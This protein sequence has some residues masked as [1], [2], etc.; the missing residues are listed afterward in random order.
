[1]TTLIDIPIPVDAE[2]A[3]ALSDVRNRQAVG[4]LLSRLLHPRPGADRLA[5]A[6][7]ELK[8]EVVASALTDEQIDAE[9]EKYNR[10]MRG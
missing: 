2:A 6:I 9:L 8:A 4:R 7:A 1:M 5:V 3:A 10:E